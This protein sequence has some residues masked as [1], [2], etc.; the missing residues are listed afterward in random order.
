MLR[1]LGT[2]GV[3]YNTIKRVCIDRKLEETSIQVN[4]KDF[5]LKYKI[6]YI[7]K[8]KES[9]IVNIKAEYEDLKNISKATG[10]PVKDLQVIFQ[11]KVSKISKDFLN[12]LN[13]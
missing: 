8:G 5:R 4:E 10:V 9:I 12:R 6:S 1:E 13:H 2:L 11:S 3:R 7:K